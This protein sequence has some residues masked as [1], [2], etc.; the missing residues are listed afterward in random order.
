MKRSQWRTSEL[1][2]LSFLAAAG[3]LHALG[4]ELSA[5]RPPW[6][7]AVPLAAGFFAAGVALL[8]AAKREL[9]PYRQRSDARVCA[10]VLVKTGPFALTRNP[11]YLADLALLLGVGLVTTP[12]LLVLLPVAPLAFRLHL[13][14]HEER[15]LRSR[16]GSAFDRYARRVPRWLDARSVTGLMRQHDRSG[17]ADA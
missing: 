13:I 14:R 16:F 6:V 7:I 15:E 3:A 8:L 11:I 9:A 2:A 17:A 10:N 5:W 1:V 12:W 4:P